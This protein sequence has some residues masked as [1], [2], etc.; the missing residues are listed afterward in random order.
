MS[1]NK[2]V[3]VSKSAFIIPSATKTVLGMVMELIIIYFLLGLEDSQKLR[4][5]IIFSIFCIP[6]GVVLVILNY[7]KYISPINLLFDYIDSINNKDLTYQISTKDMKTQKSAFSV[8]NSS[9]EK[10]SKIIK[11]VVDTSE[12]IRDNTKALNKHSS[13]IVSA[14]EQ[15]STGINNVAE[16]V[17]R[18]SEDIDIISQNMN[19]ISNQVKSL[20][21]VSKDILNKSNAA[22]QISVEGQD[23]I[24]QLK[25][26]AQENDHA[27]EEAKA[28]ID[29]L[30]KKSN[31]ITMITD[32]IIAISE[33]TNLLSLNAAIEAARAGEFGKG[34]AVVAEEVKKLAEQSSQSLKQIMLLVKGIQLQTEKTA[35]T[36]EGMG[37]LIHDQNSAVENASSKFMQISGSVNDIHSDLSNIG[38]SVEDIEKSK[39]K[40]ITL[41]KSLSDSTQNIASTSEEMASCTEEQKASI[42]FINDMITN[43][44]DL[45]KSMYDVLIKFKI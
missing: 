26:K 29:E 42:G 9:T 30:R 37:A 18:H 27:N 8:L 19:K 43:M 28:A 13:E 20:S 14:T 33:Q 41:M 39:D 25:E 3:V 4:F 6:G 16:N 23:M 12:Q 7:V 5:I 36:I 40:L 11:R 35:Q 15:V 2:R 32:T 24:L 17:R 21:E 1:N 38:K 34:F 44:N 10:I 31:E 22:H 45:T